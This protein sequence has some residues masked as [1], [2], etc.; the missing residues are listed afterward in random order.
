MVKE[1][2]FQDQIKLNKQSS[3]TLLSSK[4][5]KVSTVKVNSLNQYACHNHSNKKRK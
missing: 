3:C 1:Y 5:K 2:I 4:R